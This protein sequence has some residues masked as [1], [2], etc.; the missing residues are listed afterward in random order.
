MVI[1]V[2]D[3]SVNN[4]N[5]CMQFEKELNMQN[6]Y[7]TTESQPYYA[8]RR[9]MGIKPQR[10]IIITGKHTLYYYNRAREKGYTTNWC[11]EN[12]ICM[13]KKRSE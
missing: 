9:V 5:I 13:S 4:I 7:R 10:M 2:M 8:V 6:V 1:D 11:G 12:K 3:C